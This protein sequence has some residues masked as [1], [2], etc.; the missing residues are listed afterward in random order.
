MTDDD[1][2]WFALAAG[3]VAIAL[4]ILSYLAVN[5]WRLLAALVACSS[6]AGAATVAILGPQPGQL[7]RFNLSADMLP[8]AELAV[9]VVSAGFALWAAVFAIRKVVTWWRIGDRREA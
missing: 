7:E 2:R 5:R 6:A 3:L 1:Q 8:D 9:R 4:A